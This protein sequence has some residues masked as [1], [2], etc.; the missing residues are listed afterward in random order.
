M[1][2]HGP[3]KLGALH[4]AL[5]N[6]RV[7]SRRLFIILVFFEGCLPRQATVEQKAAESAPIHFFRPSSRRLLLRA[8]ER[9]VF[10][11]IGGR[12]GPSLEEL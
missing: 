12:V 1:I 11:F 8:H 7:L 4:G 10:F 9:S 3:I 5:L 6:S 2:M